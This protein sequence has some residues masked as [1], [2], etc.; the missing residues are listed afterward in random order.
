M[1]LRTS[2][3]GATVM[4]G[5]GRCTPGSLFFHLASIA[6]SVVVMVQSAMLIL[7]HSRGARGPGAGT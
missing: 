7:G 4:T 3:R 1:R 2:N 5:R 6:V